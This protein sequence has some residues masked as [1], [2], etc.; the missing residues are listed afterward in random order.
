MLNNGPLDLT[1]EETL[2]NVLT[3]LSSDIE[4]KNDPRLCPNYLNEVNWTILTM[5]DL[6]IIRNKLC[7]LLSTID[8]RSWTVNGYNYS[9][10]KIKSSVKAACCNRKAPDKVVYYVT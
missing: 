3:A 8:Q 4:A 6:H 5:E 10:D 7:V 2:N 1:H 9:T